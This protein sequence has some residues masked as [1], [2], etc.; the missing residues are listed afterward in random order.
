ML[1]VP[2][3]QVNYELKNYKQE[4]DDSEKLNAN[5]K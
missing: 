1:D 3:K 5:F 4:L 2:T